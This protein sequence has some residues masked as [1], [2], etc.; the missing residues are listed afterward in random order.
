LYG[1]SVPRPAAR[2]RQNPCRRSS[3][4][5]TKCSWRLPLATIR[6]A[7]ADDES[8]RRG[9]LGL[10]GSGDIVLRENGVAVPSWRWN[11][12]L[13]GD[14]AAVVVALTDAGAKRIA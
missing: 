11:Q 14:L 10:L 12:A 1:E 8:F 4:R 5:S 13:F 3:K 7:Y 9:I 2:I 6:S